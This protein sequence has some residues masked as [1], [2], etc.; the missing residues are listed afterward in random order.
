MSNSRAAQ[1]AAQLIERLERLARL[2][3]SSVR[4]NPAQ[5]D[6]LRYFARAN[7]F[8]RTPAALAAYLASTRG[9][10]SRTLVSLETKGYL[11]RG[12]SER[13]GRS[14]EFG[15]T[16]KGETALRSDPI[17]DLASD[18]EAALGR[19]LAA[20]PRECNRTQSGSPFWGLLHLPAFSYK[21]FAR[22][23][24]AVSLCA[25]ERAAFGRGFTLHMRGART[26][27][28]LKEAAPE[29]RQEVRF[30][31]RHGRAF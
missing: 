17:V 31:D 2:G 1:E 29:R 22:G 24:H 9:T 16:R 8:S 30:A 26:H 25:I 15:L 18:I 20:H 14:V 7:R 21:Q 4:L 19:E 11:M 23:G 12:K 13:D 28:G 5:W 3:E 6:A 10:V 27:G